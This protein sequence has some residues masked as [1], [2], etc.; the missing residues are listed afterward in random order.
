[1]A[2][3]GDGPMLKFFLDR[4]FPRDRVVHLDLPP[5]ERAFDAVGMLGAIIDAVGSG[6]IAPSEAAALASLVEARARIMSDAEITSRLDDLEQ[7]QK[8]IQNCLENWRP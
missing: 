8:E 7:R 3:A 5:M 4:I 1:M 6:Q 2:K